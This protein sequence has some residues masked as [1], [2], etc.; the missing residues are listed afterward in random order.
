MLGELGRRGDVALRRGAN[1]GQEAVHVTTLYVR[2]IVGA[3][4]VAVSRVAK[5]SR[6]LVWNYQ[7]VAADLRRPAQGEPPELPEPKGRAELRVLR[8]GE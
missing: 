4:S 1:A 5:E 3:L 2:R 8:P 7:D 6:D